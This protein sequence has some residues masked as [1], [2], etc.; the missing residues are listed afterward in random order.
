[1]KAHRN[2]AKDAGKE[3]SAA[4]KFFGTD[5]LRIS[6]TFKTSIQNFSVKQTEFASGSCFQT[7]N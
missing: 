2:V 3:A 6:V 5:C 4:A 1:M 7:Q